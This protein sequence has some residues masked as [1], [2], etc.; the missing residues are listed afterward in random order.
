MRHYEGIF[1]VVREDDAGQGSVGGSKSWPRGRR[2]G[3]VVRASL[4]PSKGFLQAL[5]LPLPGGV[6]GRKRAD[7]WAL[8]ICALEVKGGTQTPLPFRTGPCR[9]R[10]VRQPL[11]DR[12]T[13]RPRGMAP[14]VGPPVPRPRLHHGMD[15]FRL[16]PFRRWRASPMRFC[17]PNSTTQSAV[18]T[19]TALAYD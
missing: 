1:C 19:L 14:C 17:F 13:G 6:G 2:G 10:P 5:K 16:L 7:P 11:A 15:C 9:R 8:R 4:L 18:T 3:G 12:G